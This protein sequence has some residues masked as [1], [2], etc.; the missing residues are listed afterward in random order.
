MLAI[1]CLVAVLLYIP[2]EDTDLVVIVRRSVVRLSDETEV[3][4]NVLVCVANFVQNE[5]GDDS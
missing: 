5:K 4:R 3:L 2:G 1:G